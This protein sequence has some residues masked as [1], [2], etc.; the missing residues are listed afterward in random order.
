MTRKSAGVGIAVEEKVDLPG[1]H[2]AI[3]RIGDTDDRAF[4]T[5]VFQC[6]Q[7]MEEGAKCK[8]PLIVMLSL[9]S[10]I[11]LLSTE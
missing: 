5:I 3:C 6:Q 8:P 1:D 7:I 9:R 2:F 10:R 4:R 11:L